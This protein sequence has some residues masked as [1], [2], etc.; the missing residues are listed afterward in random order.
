MYPNCVTENMIDDVTLTSRIIANLLSSKFHYC[1]SYC[2][3]VRRDMREIYRHNVELL[4][5]NSFKLQFRI[6][7][8]VGKYMATAALQTG[9]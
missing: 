9:N 1:I 3:L 8:V 6:V 4:L 7:K 5:F 2:E